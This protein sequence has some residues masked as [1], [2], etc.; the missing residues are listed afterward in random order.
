MQSRLTSAQTAAFTKYFACL[1]Q[2]HARA[3]QCA[4][5][6]FDQPCQG[7]HIRVVKT[8]RAPMLTGQRL[9]Q[10]DPN[11]KVI[12]TFRDPRG[13]ARSRSLAS[14]SQGHYEGPSPGR[15]AQCYCQTVNADFR[16][17]MQL[18]T[19]F[20]NHLHYFIF[21]DYVERPLEVAH[22]IL[23]F[24]EVP[25]SAS[26]KEYLKSLPTAKQ[27]PSQDRNKKWKSSF[28]PNQIAV[29]NSVCK[30]FYTNIPFHWPSV[31]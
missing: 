27:K 18:M 12:Q 13:V 2:F 11:A 3:V 10:S 1:D 28:T 17:G 31:S 20:P 29:I 30:D 9:L 21:D 4:R 7:K 6:H 8:V 15:I 14:W 23:R 22:E 26:L 24:A 25:L 19:T 16:L 5:K